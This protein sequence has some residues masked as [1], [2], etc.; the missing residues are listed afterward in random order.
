MIDFLRWLRD[1]AARL[2][3]KVDLPLLLALLCVM[4]ISLVVLAS[5]SGE[6]S[7]LVLSQ[8][9]RLSLIG[10]A[11]GLGLAVA[12]TR[13]LQSLLFEVQPTDP[14]TLAAASA[15]VVLVTLI[16]SYAP[17]HRASRLNPLAA[18][19]HE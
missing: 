13:A 11:I 6:N 10:V 12:G 17:A 2:L 1:L 7:R 4:L 8:G 5:A 9:A 14:L 16:A 15:V 3:D 19:R 18:L